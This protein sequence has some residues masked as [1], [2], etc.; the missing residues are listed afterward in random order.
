[1]SQVR[2]TI[3][4]IQNSL[5]E[6]FGQFV[7]WYWHWNQP[8]PLHKLPKL[9]RSESLQLFTSILD[10]YAGMLEGYGK[11]MKYRDS[12]D[13]SGCTLDDMFDTSEFLHRM[14]RSLRP[15]M[16]RFVQT[17]L[18]SNLIVSKTQC[19][20]TSSSS[21][22][23]LLDFP[24]LFFDKYLTLMSRPFEDRFNHLRKVL[25]KHSNRILLIS[26]HSGQENS[27]SKSHS[28]DVDDSTLD[29][30][31]LGELTDIG[32]NLILAAD[33][34][35][36]ECNIQLPIKYS[37]HSDRYQCPFC[38]SKV[39]PLLRVFSE[40]EGIQTY[41]LLTPQEVKESED[42]LE[43]LYSR[44]V[45][46]SLRKSIQPVLPLSLASMLF[47]LSP[48]KAFVRSVLNAWC[49][50][51]EEI[52]VENENGWIEDMELGIFSSTPMLAENGEL[53]L[54]GLTPDVIN[55]VNEI[56]KYLSSGDVETA[57]KLFLYCRG[58]DVHECFH[59]YSPFVLCLK[60]R[61]MG[62]FLELCVL[63]TN[64]NVAGVRQLVDKWKMQYEAVCLV[65][66]CGMDEK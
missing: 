4:S 27:P 30:L 49:G 42:S 51:N 64:F 54:Q 29:S 10:V 24:V 66:S 38:L 3:E 14:P 16:S 31:S 50:I 32:S 20:A 43:C 22:L 35:C 58:G 41:S 12:G 44:Y 21:L 17:Q 52:M 7:D 19:S 56:I 26:L 48:G 39:N 34:Y 37:I 60:T 59:R 62:E 1:M 47:Y 5:Q 25:Y 6:H 15:F 55:M 33:I 11:T 57:C 2:S 61:P 23:A 40:E 13:Y 36:A 65:W 18:F 53:I 28:C 45:L 63:L 9:S 46:S 8:D